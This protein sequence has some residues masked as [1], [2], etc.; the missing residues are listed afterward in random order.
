MI[1]ASTGWVQRRNQVSSSHMLTYSPFHSLPPSML[2]V[3][4]INLT[5]GMAK[6]EQVPEQVPVVVVVVQ[7]NLS[8]IGA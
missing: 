1:S 6:L 8:V 3:T 5:S 7:G 4:L 2:I